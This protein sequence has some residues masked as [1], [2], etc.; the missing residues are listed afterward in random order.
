MY[1]LSD[2]DTS[3][4]SLHLPLVS[5]NHDRNLDLSLSLEIAHIT[6]FFNGSVG[7]FGRPLQTTYFV[8][9]VERLIN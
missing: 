3:D 9:L 4:H 2:F 8:I 1:K 7:H 6:H 5:F